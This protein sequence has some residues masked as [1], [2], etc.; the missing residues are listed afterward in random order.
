VEDTDVVEP[1]AGY[2]LQV[3]AGVR[4]VE[5]LPGVEPAAAGRVVDAEAELTDGILLG[6][7]ARRLLFCANVSTTIVSD[8]Q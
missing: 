5:V 7:G 2:L 8:G 4:R 1:Q 6:F 3:L